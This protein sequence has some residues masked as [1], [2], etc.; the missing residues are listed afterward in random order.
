MRLTLL[1][2]GLRRFNEQVCFSF[3]LLQAHH[4]VEVSAQSSAA[5]VLSGGSRSK[6][7]RRTRA[8]SLLRMISMVMMQIPKPKGS[9][10]AVISKQRQLL[11]A[12]EC[13]DCNN[14][15]DAL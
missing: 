7:Q 2:A 11:P 6:M 12:L 10:Q 8:R 3:F 9:M 4:R 5:V 13:T 14:V 1:R 15:V